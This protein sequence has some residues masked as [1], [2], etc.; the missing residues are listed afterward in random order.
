MRFNPQKTR[1]RLQK[2]LAKVREAL[3]AIDPKA[4]DAS[5]KATAHAIVGEAGEVLHKADSENEIMGRIAE[6]LY[7]V[8]EA[9]GNGESYPHIRDFYLRESSPQVVY[10]L[11]RKLYRREAAFEGDEIN[12][13][14]PVEVLM[15]YA[16]VEDREPEAATAAE[17]DPEGAKVLAIEA[18]GSGLVKII[19]AGQGSSGNWT[20]EALR[21]DA[22]EAWPAGTHMYWNHPTN[23]EARERPERDLEALAGVLESDAAWRDDGPAG[24]G[25]YAT[26][27]VRDPFRGAIEDMRDWIGVSVRAMVSKEGEDI[28]QVHPGPINSVD[29]V[30]KP[31]AG[32]KVLEAF[33]AAGRGP[34]Q[35]TQQTKQKEKPMEKEQLRE[36]I[37]EAMQPFSDRLEKL[38]GAV[39]TSQKATESLARRMTAAEVR[40]AARAL[41]KEADIPEAAK[42]RV[43][44]S[45][46]A[47][48]KLDAN[49]ALDQQAFQTQAQEAIKAE[50]DY[51]AALGGGKVEGMGGGA[52]ETA[53]ESYDF[54]PMV[55]YYIKR[56]LSVEQAHEAAGVPYKEVTQ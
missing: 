25:V 44:E 33:E 6:A 12:F 40:D 32:G 24:P 29:F 19:E 56:G 51:I 28:T 3:L 7:R 18:A 8:L 2:T 47:S 45:I 10:E 13:G 30:T 22:G 31:G 46:S 37:G 49:G 21:R 11:R 35:P 50:T 17:S 20:R 39:G 42:V 53:E 16:D 36:L 23:S 14:G 41:V 5:V 9:E 15:Q 34:Q 52:P 1:E 54:G 48:P 26:A 4:A 43:V 38:E 27:K 55:Q